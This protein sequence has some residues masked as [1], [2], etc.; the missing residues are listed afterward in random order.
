[1]WL[2][3]IDATRARECVERVEDNDGASETGLVSPALDLASP[4]TLDLTL[5]GRGLDSEILF[6]L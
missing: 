4:D 2:A 5:I 1:M 3:D 6:W